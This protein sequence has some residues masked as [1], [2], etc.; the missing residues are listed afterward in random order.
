MYVN[1]GTCLRRHFAVSPI[2]YF[3]FFGLA[4]PAATRHAVEHNTLCDF[5]REG[6]KQIACPLNGSDTHCKFGGSG[7]G[8]FA[9]LSLGTGC[10]GLG[11]WKPGSLDVRL[12]LAG[13]YCLLSGCLA[14]C[15]PACLPGWLLQAES[16]AVVGQTV[17]K[18]TASP[19]QP[20]NQ[21]H[22]PL[23]HQANAGEVSVTPDCM[24]VWL[25]GSLEA[26]QPVCLAAWLPGC[27]AA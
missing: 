7:G 26:C 15:L 10:R 17:R 8:L 14:G 22:Q 18:L 21:R 4:F 24:P 9:C 16:I 1:L 20:P 11:A 5:P 13:C 25:T 23:R 6:N 3:W 2:A 12:L 27:M 19:N